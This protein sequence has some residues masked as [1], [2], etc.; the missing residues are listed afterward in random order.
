MS[1]VLRVTPAE[2]SEIYLVTFHKDIDE[3]FFEQTLQGLT[4]HI[5]EIDRIIMVSVKN[6]KFDRI[7]L[8]DKSILRLGTFELFYSDFS[9]PHAVVINEAVELAKKFGTEESGAFV[10]GVL[11][12]VRKKTTY[13]FG[14]GI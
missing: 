4:S 6:W 11:D 1:D 10:N 8:V 14:G 2:A 7:S 3:E 13:D 9:I 5:D 12:A